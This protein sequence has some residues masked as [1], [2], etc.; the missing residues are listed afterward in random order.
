MGA[1]AS[2]GRGPGRGGDGR[3]GQGPPQATP[4]TGRGRQ[5]G[6]L[7]GQR[8][9][10]RVGDPVAGPALGRLDGR[11]DQ[12]EPPQRA[13]Q[14]VPV[15]G[16]AA[17]DL[18]SRPVRDGELAEGRGAGTSWGRPDRYGLRKEGRTR[19]HRRSRRS[20]RRSFHPVF[21][22]VGESFL[23]SPR[24]ISAGNSSGVVSTCRSRNSRN[25]S[26]SSTIRSDCSRE[27]G[28]Q[29]VF[30][31]RAGSVERSAAGMVPSLL[32]T[33]EGE[34]CAPQHS[35]PLPGLPGHPVPSPK[36]VISRKTGRGRFIYSRSVAS[37]M[38]YTPCGA[39]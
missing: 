14:A 34:I 5:G 15:P 9:G 8:G 19:T 22:E 36:S 35:R 37:R 10:L 23:R 39:E 32:R 33:H 24:R 18:G 13:F 12:A 30:G 1:R 16:R 21:W 28:M 20:I 2:P 6:L 7:P 11:A 38:I 17:E 4:G 25:R 3:E 29:M 31:P 27:Q 26:G